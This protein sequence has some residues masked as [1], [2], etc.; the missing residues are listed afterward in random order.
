[1]GT[2]QRKMLLCMVLTI[3]ST[4]NFTCQQDSTQKSS[5]RWLLLLDI[6]A[7]SLRLAHVKSTPVELLCLEIW[8]S[9]LL[10]QSRLHRFG[11]DLERGRV[12]SMQLRMHLLDKKLLKVWLNFWWFSSNFLKDLKLN[13]KNKS[14]KILNLLRKKPKKRKRMK[15]FQTF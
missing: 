14:K 1:M 10:I 15:I 5:Q 11:M 13:R 8:T 7:V 3:Q 9:V 12:S 2:Q 6:T 4:I